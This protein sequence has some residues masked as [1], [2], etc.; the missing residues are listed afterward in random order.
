MTGSGVPCRNAPD[1][2]EIQTDRCRLGWV[3]ALRCTRGVLR[4]TWTYSPRMYEAATI[5]GVARTYQDELE[6]LIRHCLDEHAGGLTPSDVPLAQLT[7]RQIDAWALP[8][9]EI[10]DVY[11][12]SPLQQGILFHALRAPQSGH[13]VN[14]LCVTVAGLDVERFKVAWAA[15]IARHTALRTGLIWEGDLPGPLQFV[16]Q[17]VPSALTQ[18]DWRDRDVDTAGLHA[19]AAADREKQF[20]LTQPPLQRMTVV[21]LSDGAHHLIWTHH[22]LLLDGWSAARQIEEVFGHY[23]GETLSPVSSR[24]GQYVAWL[25]QQDRAISEKF[26]RQVLEPV[27][28]PTLLAQ[29][30]GRAPVQGAVDEGVEA[31][32]VCRWEPVMSHQWVQFARC[33]RVTLHTLIQAAW[34]LL[35]QSYCGQRTVIFGSTVA[36]RPDAL[37]GSH[38]MVGLLINTLP[39]IESPRPEQTVGAWLRELQARNSALRE[40]AHVPLYE[41]QRWAGH[42][43]QTLFDTLLVFEN[44][45]VDTALRARFGALLQ[46]GS[47]TTV[48]TTHYPLTV[49]VHT[50]EPLEIR[51]SYSRAHFTF[52]QIAALQGHLAALLQRLTADAAG[53]LGELTLLTSGQRIASVSI[54]QG[55]ISSCEFRC[56]HELFEM[57]AKAQPQA[58]AV[59]FEN[60][61]LSYGELN[62]RANQL[63]RHLRAQGVGPEVRVG[64]AMERSVELVVGMLAIL[65]AGGAYVPL[66]PAYPTQR[67]AFMIGDAG[68]ERVLTQERLL[69]R[70]PHAAADGET[71]RVRADRDTCPQGESVLAW[72]LDRNWHEVEH[73]AATD[74]ENLASEQ[75]LAYCM[76]TSGSTG[77]PKA[78]P[79]HTAYSATC[80]RGRSVP[81]RVRYAPYSFRLSVLM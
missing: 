26:W 30:V 77:R 16:R 40:H 79:C 25:R 56:L 60:T 15:V 2:R 51:F 13:Y 9:R 10:E 23:L 21:Q 49:S 66:D 27:A 20:D 68:L 80:S 57:R 39:V 43:G 1:N 74:L 18:L 4:L 71:M 29:A 50:A 32:E 5:E 81:R 76:Y 78:V 62:A 8:V 55:E 34:A 52:E 44:Y 24:Y 7:Q 41:V 33:E 11:P 36:G 17:Q 69:E 6:A 46:F 58:V 47:A 70:L 45:P 73:Q 48:Q 19:L 63:A 53:Y 14:Q 28:E 54:D 22:H 59:V 38:E 37:R 65:K 72:C 12:L 61:S 67:L 35:L 3:S 75:N 64:L 42:P 31:E